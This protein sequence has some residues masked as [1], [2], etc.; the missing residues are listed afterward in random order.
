MWAVHEASHA[1]FHK[2]VLFFRSYEV[3][4]GVE[5]VINVSHSVTNRVVDIDLVAQEAT[6]STE[7]FTNWK[8][9]GDLSVMN[10][11]EIPYSL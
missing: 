8:P 2:R 1:V 11:I 3:L 9:S 10:S 6:D 4:L 5:V 7:A